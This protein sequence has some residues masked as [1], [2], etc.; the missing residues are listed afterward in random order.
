MDALASQLGD[1]RGRRPL[2]GQPG[3]ARIGAD[4]FQGMVATNAQLISEALGG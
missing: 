4:T 1:D 2:R 3:R